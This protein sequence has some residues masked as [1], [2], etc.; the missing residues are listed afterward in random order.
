MLFRSIA[1]VTYYTSGAC[2]YVVGSGSISQAFSISGSASVTATCGIFVNSS[3]STAYTESGSS[4]VKASQILINGTSPGYQL[5]GSS[6]VSPTPT[7]NAGPQSD[8]LSSQVEPTF[9]N[10]C[11]SPPYSGYSLSGSGSATLP[12]G[13]YCGGISISGSS[14]ATFSSGNY[15]IYG[16]LTISGSATVTLGSGVYIVNGGGINISGSTNV[17]GTGVAF[18]DT[19]QYG[20]TIGAVNTSGSSTLNLTAPNSG[21]Y[22]G[23]LFLQDRNLSYSGANSVSGSSSSVLTGTLYFPTTTI[24]YSGSSSTGSYTA[25]IAKQISFS[26]SANFKND[27]TGQYTGLA[28]TIRGLIQ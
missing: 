1:A 13:N 24:D 17:S 15:I 2:I 11:P 12:S 3:S 6:S 21:S 18:F 19:G 27:P 22:Q 16:G 8:P 20:Q 25:L 14:R 9:S 5:S 7:T 26:G 23:M 4:T 28:T 10:V